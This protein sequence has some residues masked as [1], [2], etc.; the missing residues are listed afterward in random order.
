MLSREA[1]ET[2][3][4]KIVERDA[5]T[6]SVKKRKHTHMGNDVRTTEEIKSKNKKKK[7][8]PEEDL[9]RLNES[10]RRKKHKKK[11]FNNA[12]VCKTNVTPKVTNRMMKQKRKNSTKK[13]G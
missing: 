5:K 13:V 2:G 8:I 12:D 3:L 7:A 6:F 11:M 10:K 4:L 1:F 9:V